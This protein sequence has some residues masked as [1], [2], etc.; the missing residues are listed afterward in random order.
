MPSKPA[1]YGLKYWSLVDVDS[2][3][4]LDI[5]PYLGKAQVAD[6]NEK[7]VGLK[8]SF[9]LCK[10]YFKSSR[11]SLTVDNFFNSVELAKKLWDEN[12]TLVGDNLDLRLIY[13]F[14]CF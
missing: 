5:I 11:R 13:L 3:Y 7:N 10:P 6:P 4:L 12:I 9:A 1:K 2:T 8:V 14:S